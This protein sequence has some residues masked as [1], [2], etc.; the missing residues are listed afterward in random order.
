MS[1]DTRAVDAAHDIPAHA[2]A[3]ERRERTRPGGRAGDRS[4]RQ[5]W[6]KILLTG[7]VLY[8]TATLL[9]ASSGAPELV[10]TVLVLSAFLPPVSVAA[11]L[12]GPRCAANQ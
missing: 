1:E 10:P 3:R 6:W 2:V 12:Y 7:I 9:L 8:L 5:V 11:F 4:G